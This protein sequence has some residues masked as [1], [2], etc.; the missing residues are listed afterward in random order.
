MDPATRPA[1]EGLLT[2]AERWA[3]EEAA[4]WA[5]WRDAL[6]GDQRS[7]ALLPLQAALTGLV[8][9]RQLENHPLS[10][11]IS[12]FRPHLMSVSAGYDW[13]LELVAELRP[14]LSRGAPA[15]RADRQTA[16][17]TPSELLE[18]LEVSLTDG[19][20]VARRL[21]ELT[22]ID[23][24]AFQASCDLFLR[25]L[26]RNPFFRPPAPLEF[27]NVRELVHAESLTPAL[28]SWHSDAAKITT[29]VAFLTLVRAHRFLGIADSALSTPDGPYRAQL[30]IAAV[31]RELRTFTRFLMVQGVETLAQEFERRLVGLEAHH[32]TGTYRKIRETTGEL[33]DMRAALEGLAMRIHATARTELDHP[34][35]VEGGPLEPLQTVDALHSGIA[36]VRRTVKAAARELRK[37][38]QPGPAPLDDGELE[39][40]LRRDVWAFRL[41]LRAFLAKANAEPP[42]PTGAAV[43]QFAHEFARHYRAFARRLLGSTH[44]D[45]RGPLSRAVGALSRS[46]A[47]FE[48]L[49]EAAVE[50]QALLAHLDHVFD[51]QERVRSGSPLD[52]RVAAEEL[53]AYLAGA[54]SRAEPETPNTVAVSV[55]GGP[56]GRAADAS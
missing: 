6:T 15:P 2:W 34:I 33:D 48:D 11:T 22:V 46:D 52:K 19:V 49:E 44:Y 3:P 21:L 12:D 42:R 56:R 9:Y 32:V 54:G 50:A 7:F 30:V 35:A 28:A 14:D 13:A 17:Q 20:R 45:R 39:T 38:A 16:A 31:R 25:D 18:R 43:P 27:A 36:E 8:A 26:D 1:D 37:L 24:G 51:E 47:A 23:A 4:A 55:F 40:A 29:T 53:R 5:A 41:I 10:S